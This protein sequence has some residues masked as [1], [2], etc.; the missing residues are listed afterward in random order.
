MAQTQLPIQSRNEKNI[1]ELEVAEINEISDILFK[2]LDQKVKAIEVMEAALNKKAAALVLLLQKAEAFLA[3]GSSL[4]TIEQLDQKA[5]AA[6]AIGASLD[7]KIAMLGLL[8]QKAE[9]LSA[10]VNVLGDT[11]NRRHEIVALQKKGLGVKEI[12]EVLDMPQGEV[13]LILNLHALNA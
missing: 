13:D 1:L 4:R 5:Q 12:A 9:P 11:P 3:S 2:K 6:E 7:K 8:L 10:S